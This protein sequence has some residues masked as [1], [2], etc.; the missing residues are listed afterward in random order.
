MFHQAMIKRMGVFFLIFLFRA[1]FAEQVQGEL[2]DS[3]DAKHITFPDKRLTVNGL[4]WF[5]E[6]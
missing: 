1:S 3:A 4:A 5:G 6:D 2:V